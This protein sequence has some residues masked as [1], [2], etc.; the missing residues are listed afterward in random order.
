MIDIPVTN[1]EI[2]IDPEQWATLKKN[3]TKEDIIETIS[4]VIENQNISFPITNNTLSTAIDDFKRLEKENSLKFIKRGEF[5]HRYDYKTPFNDIYIG[6]SLTGLKSSNYFNFETRMA[7]DSINSPSPYRTWRTHKFRKSMLGAL[8]SLK[9]DEVNSKALSTCISM[10]KYI[11]SQFRPSCA[12]CIFQLFNAKN[13]LDFSSGWGDRLSG[14]L[15][16][17]TTE[18]YIGIDPN[19][20][21]FD[22]Y[23]QQCKEINLGLGLNKQILLLNETA[24]DAFVF[25]HDIDLIFTSP[26]YFNIERYT[27]EDNQSF[28]KYRKLQTWLD[29]FLFFSIN[30]YWENLKD[31]GIL[32]I[33]IGDVYSNHTVNNICDPMNEFIS[34]L[35]DA[36]Y[37]GC[38]GYKMQKRL[39]SKSDKK[40]IFAEPIWIWGKNVKGDIETIV[41]DRLS[42]F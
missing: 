42:N 18:K 26:P 22:G 11:A 39:R 16:T 5:S 2:V 23:S 28:K 32:A 33:N 20:S 35:K 4:S 36:S 25:D 21:L 34:T 40:G 13:V 41:N 1:N 6:S 24:E 15:A 27:Q 14:F 10:R 9:M 3:H 29:K 19:A 17:H 31:G 12:K 8:F 7:C 30:K 38:I 37:L